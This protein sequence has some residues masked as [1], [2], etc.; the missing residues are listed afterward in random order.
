MHDADPRPL[1]RLGNLSRSSRPAASPTS[2]ARCRPRLKARRRRGPHAGAGLSR[3]AW[4]RSRRREQMLRLAADLFG[5]PARLL[6]ATRGGLDLFVL[7]AP[8]LFA[9]P[10]NPYRRRRT[11][12]TGR[13]TALRFAALA[14]D[15]RPISASAPSPAFV[16]DVVH[17][18]DWQAGLAPAYLHYGGAPRPGTVMTMHNLAFQG[19][20]PR[21]AARRARP[22]AG[23]LR[24]RRRR[25]LRRRSAF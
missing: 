3:R 19:Q 17:A 4:R 11:A 7:D 2:P 18:H 9:R 13:T 20:F 5:G 15:R 23:V 24:D 12:R 1:G 14:R 6:A 22:A 21:R 10:G 25:I 8:H 16:P